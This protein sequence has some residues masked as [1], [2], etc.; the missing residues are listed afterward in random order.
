[1]SSLIRRTSEFTRSG[2]QPNLG[3]HL[4]FTKYFTRFLPGFPLGSDRGSLAGGE[5]EGGRERELALLL[6]ELPL[7]RLRGGVVAGRA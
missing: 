4:V 1:M 5:E 7:R 2:R 3:F 6:R